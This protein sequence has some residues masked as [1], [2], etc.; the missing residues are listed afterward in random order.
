MR[1]HHRAGPFRHV[2]L[3]DVYQTH[4]FVFD[5]RR[6]HVALFVNMR[7]YV[8]AAFAHTYFRAI[9]R[10]PVWAARYPH[11]ISLAEDNSF[12]ISKL[13]LFFHNQGCPTGLEPVLTD[14]QSVVR[15]VT[16]WTP[17]HGLRLNATLFF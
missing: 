3:A 16:L 12:G 17:Y 13:V 11:L 6:P 2:F 1:T 9:F 4:C 14:S 7:E 5:T 10:G 15:T 8:H